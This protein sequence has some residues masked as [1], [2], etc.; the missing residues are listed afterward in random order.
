MKNLGLAK[1]EKATAKKF[2]QTVLK[3]SPWLAPVEV[4]IDECV[5]RIPKYSPIYQKSYNLPK[6]KCDAQYAFFND[7]LEVVA[8][9]VSR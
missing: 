4:A 3:G 6:E 7:C 8:F 5:D 9:S 1:I 2:V